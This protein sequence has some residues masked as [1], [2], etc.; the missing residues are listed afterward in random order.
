MNER[1]FIE[2]ITEAVLNLGVDETV[3]SMARAMIYLAHSG[4]HDIEFESD[5]GIVSINRKFITE[6]TKH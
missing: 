2:L 3:G 1:D 5:D 4:N 6:T